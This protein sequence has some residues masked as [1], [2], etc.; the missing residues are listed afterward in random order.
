VTGRVRVCLLDAATGLESPVVFLC[1]L[2]GLLEKE[3]ALGVD[4]DD[5]SEI[6]RDNTRRIYT[7]SHRKL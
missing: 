4:S 5:R 1:G 6:L 3:E 7:A 2:D